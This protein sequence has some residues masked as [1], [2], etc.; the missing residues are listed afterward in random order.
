MDR[1]IG[2]GRFFL[3]IPM[4][5]FGL[6]HFIYARLVATLV[7]SWIPWHLFW[8]YF[9]GVALIAAGA[10]SI[11]NRDQAY[12]AATLLGVMI[13]SFVLLIHAPSIVGNPKNLAG[14]QLWSSNGAG[15]RNNAQI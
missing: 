5:F 14:G 2:L 4:V 11:D 1:G 10:S 3:G 8:A 7:P 12:L 9:A 6:E 15:G 13:F